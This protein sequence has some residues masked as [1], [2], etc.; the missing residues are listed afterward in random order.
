M[1]TLPDSQSERFAAAE[2]FG[3]TARSAPTS[4][5]TIAPPRARGAEAALVALAVSGPLAAALHQAARA[6]RARRLG[7]GLAA[8]LR[9]LQ[10][11][12]TKYAE[13]RRRRA[14]AG[15]TYR[16]LG[17]LDRRTLRDLGI[18]R[19]QL[20]SVALGIARG[21]ITRLPVLR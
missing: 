10:A 5:E 8:A 4:L 6:D 14:L 20:S 21:S 19:S 11:Q 13:G 16:A 15:A 9:W 1:R 7:Q 2:S 12:L 18:D 17:A 3:R